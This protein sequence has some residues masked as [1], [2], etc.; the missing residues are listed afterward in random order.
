MGSSFQV[1]FEDKDWSISNAELPLRACLLAWGNPGY[2]LQSTYASLE[3]YIVIVFDSESLDINM[4]KVFP[5]GDLGSK[6]MKRLSPNPQWG[7]YHVY[8]VQ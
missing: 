6:T 5:A 4:I 1:T 3:S 8:S 2:I 7:V